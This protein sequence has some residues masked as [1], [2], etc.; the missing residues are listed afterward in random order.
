MTRICL[1]SL[2]TIYLVSNEMFE[3]WGPRITS[4]WM[5]LSALH[6]ILLHISFNYENHQHQPGTLQVYLHLHQRETSTIDPEKYQTRDIKM[7]FIRQEIDGKLLS[8][9]H[10][11]LSSTRAFLSSRPPSRTESLYQESIFKEI[12][13]W[14]TQ[15]IVA[16]NTQYFKR[17]FDMEMFW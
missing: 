5:A 3:T 11:P 13:N 4:G 7:I 15:Q 8:T 2:N 16:G 12:E 6:W 10:S 17:R 9:V 14:V 1:T